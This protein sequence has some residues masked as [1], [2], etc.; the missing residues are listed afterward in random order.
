MRL[1]YGKLPVKRL[2]NFGFRASPLCIWPPKVIL[3]ILD[4]LHSHVVN[5]YQKVPAW[6][7]ISLH[8]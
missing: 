8:P 7:W 6:I 3:A 5:F 4:I 2:T 1:Y